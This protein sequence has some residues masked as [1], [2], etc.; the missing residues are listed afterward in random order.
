MF[1]KPNAPTD[2]DAGNEDDGA[3]ATKKMFVTGEFVKSHE[4]LPWKLIRLGDDVRE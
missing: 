3:A 2:Q 1:D 4:I